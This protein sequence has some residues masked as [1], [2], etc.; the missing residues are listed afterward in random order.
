MPKDVDFHPAPR[1]M[2]VLFN[3][4]ES[5]TFSLMP[6][7][8]SVENDDGVRWTT[9]TRQNLRNLEAESLDADE[10]N[11]IR[12]WDSAVHGTPTLEDVLDAVRARHCNATANDLEAAEDDYRL[13]F[14]TPRTP[15][16]DAAGLEE[17]S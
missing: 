17:A 10:H 12:M 13:Y 14:G 3:D 15:T 11:L 9:L 1:P 8:A 16:T 7:W 2:W 6:G 4:E 5:V